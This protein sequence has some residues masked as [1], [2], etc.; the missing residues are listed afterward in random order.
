MDKVPLKSIMSIGRV[1]E[2]VAIGPTVGVL[3]DRGPDSIGK[4]TESVT[5]DQVADRLI[6]DS[7]GRVAESVVSG[8]SV[9]RLIG[10][11]R[12]IGCVGIFVGSVVIKPPDVKLPGMRTDL[13]VVRIESLM[14]KPPDVM[15][16]GGSPDTLGKPSE[17][18]A[19]ELP[20]VRLPGGLITGGSPVVPVVIGPSVERLEEERPVS[21]EELG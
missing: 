18:V 5:T 16:L 13:L 14:N 4:L 17:R 2:L 6:W 15:L 8:P 20:G 7:T 12:V 10:G 11:R 21:L 19:S 9:E 3:D 1:A